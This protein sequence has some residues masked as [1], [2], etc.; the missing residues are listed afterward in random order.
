MPKDEVIHLKADDFL[1]SV[2]AGMAEEE[3][4]TSKFPELLQ[5]CEDVLKASHKSE[6]ESFMKFLVDQ[7]LACSK[8]Q[9][10]LM[11]SAPRC[12]LYVKSNALYSSTK[13]AETCTSLLRKICACSDE[14]CNLFL[15][16]RVFKFN[17]AILAF[18][19]R[20]MRGG[21]DRFCHF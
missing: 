3:K 12:S 9:N 1:N 2:V 14:T 13:F 21:E 15:G 17:D 7:F 6:R 19:L 5:V 11:P 10:A 4:K 18:I 16:S 8:G 20:K